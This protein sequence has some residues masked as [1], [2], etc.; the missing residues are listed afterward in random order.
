[1]QQLYG[2]LLPVTQRAAAGVRSINT[3]ENLVEVL[4]GF[5]RYHNWHW[6]VE[7]LRFQSQRQ[8][9]QALLVPEPAAGQ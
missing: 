6:V 5:H 1:M 7:R 2:T 8:A 3:L 9:Y 4:E